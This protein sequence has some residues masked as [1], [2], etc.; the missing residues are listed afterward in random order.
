M[1]QS[2]QG[3]TLEEINRDIAK[4]KHRIGELQVLLDTQVR[5]DNPMVRN[6]ES[7]I[8]TTLRDV[9]GRESSEYKECSYVRLRSG[10]IS[11]GDFESELS[12]EHRKQN[13]FTRNVHASMVKLQ[14]FVKRLEEEKEDFKKCPRCHRTYPNLDYCLEDG[15]F[16]VGLSYDPDSPTLPYS[17]NG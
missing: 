7:E 2:S 3:R 17:P 9:F 16:L 5:Y 11:K 8:P 6:A 12:A 1:I 4:I 14:G 13:E 15:T 10:I